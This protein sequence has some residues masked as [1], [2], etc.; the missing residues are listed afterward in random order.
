MTYYGRIIDIIQLNYS[1]QFSVDLFKC[2]WV[3]IS[4]KGI[5]K[6]KYGY[7]LVN[8]SHLMHKGDKIEHEAFILP[9]QADQVFYLEDELNPGWSV[10]M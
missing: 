4:E 5:K 2:E 9:N 10:V 6:D 7:T 8:F 1:G 3:D